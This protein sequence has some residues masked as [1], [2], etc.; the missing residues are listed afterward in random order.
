VICR[1]DPA[2]S[3]FAVL[4]IVTNSGH[5]MPNGGCL[6]IAN[7]TALIDA[8]QS[9]LDLASGAYAKIAI[10]DSGHGMPTDAAAH[11]FELFFTTRGAGT[12]TGLGLSQ[13]YG[14][15]KQSGGTATG[16]H[17]NRSRVLDGP[18]DG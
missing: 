10:L 17:A 9:K 2:E 15:A 4:D 7:G 12:G 16:W 8:A 14:F 3:D 6:K 18:L 13:V 5:A 1:I 11:A